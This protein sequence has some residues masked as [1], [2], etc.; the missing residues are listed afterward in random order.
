MPFA[1]LRPVGTRMEGRS[2]SSALVTGNFFQ[3]LG[4]QAALG[5]TLMPGDD[6]RLPVGR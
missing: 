1:M 3:M 5:R 4:V 6:E 2:V